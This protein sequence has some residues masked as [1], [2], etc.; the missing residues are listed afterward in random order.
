MAQQR[1]S[2]PHRRNDAKEVDGHRLNR[3]DRAGDLSRGPVLVKAPALTN[4]RK[5]HHLSL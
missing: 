5:T 3:Q 4:S 2:I 1:L